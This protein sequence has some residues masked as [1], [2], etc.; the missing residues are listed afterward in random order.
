MRISRL[1][2]AFHKIT[3]AN[4]LMN[5]GIIR[6]YF[7]VI[8][9]VIAFRD[10]KVIILLIVIHLNIIR[11]HE[12][13]IFLIIF[14]LV[15][16]DKGIIILFVSIIQM[17]Q[18]IR[19]CRFAGL[20][21]RFERFFQSLDRTRRVAGHKLGITQFHNVLRIFL[22]AQLRLIY[23]L[24]SFQSFLK[25][26][27]SQIIICQRTAGLRKISRIWIFFHKSIQAFFRILLLKNHADYIAEK[28]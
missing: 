24:Q 20:I 3:L 13:R 17:S 22:T 2:I 12:M 10:C 6:S 14:D 1:V 27:F 15:K 7:S 18:H 4:Y 23:I 26:L 28:C 9:N 21:R 25:I 5:F 8:Q 19:D 16:I 11:L